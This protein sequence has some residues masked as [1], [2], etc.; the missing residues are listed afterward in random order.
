M[1]TLSLPEITSAAGHKREVP[2]VSGN[3]R[4][5]CESGPD[6]DVPGLPPLTDAVEK[7]F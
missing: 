6:A 7:R 2:T 5:E 1:R 3:V 4:D